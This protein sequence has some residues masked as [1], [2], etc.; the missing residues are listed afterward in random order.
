M[1]RNSLFATMTIPS[2]DLIKRDTPASPDDDDG[3]K[4]L[5]LASYYAAQA[6]VTVYMAS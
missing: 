6:P 1:P 5:Q 2:S 3:R 4:A